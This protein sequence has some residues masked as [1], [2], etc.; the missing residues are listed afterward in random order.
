MNRLLLHRL[1]WL[2]V[3]AFLFSSMLT[4]RGQSPSTDDELTLHSAGLSADGAALLAF[5]HARA[6]TDIDRDHLLLLLRQFASG[7]K[8]ERDSATVELLGLGPLALPILRQA[9]ND[10][11]HPEVAKRAARCLPWLEGASSHKL[12]AA[13]AHLLAQRKPDGAAAALL[14]YLPFADN[15][16]VIQAVNTA[17]AAV[18]VQDGKPDPALLR[19]LTDPLAVRRAAAGIALCRATPPDRVPAVRKLLQDPAPG[20]RLHAAMALAEANDAGAIPVLIDL[21]ADLTP[22]Q[23]QPVEELLTQLAGEWAPAMQFSSED[24]ISR[25]IRRDAWASWWRHTDGPALLAAVGKHTLTPEA[26]A[27]V[28]GYIA[29]LGSEQFTSRENATRDL[30]A[31]G[32]ITLPQ[33]REAS[34]NKDPEVARRAKLLIERIEREPAHHLPVAAI[35]LLA[36]R[37]PAGVVEALLAYVPHAEDEARIEE[38]RKSLTVL[39]LRDG[40]LDPLLVRALSDT[41]PLVRV[42]AVQALAKGGGVEGR[43]AV[44]QL[45]KDDAPVVRLRVALA[46]ALAKEKDS[47]PVLIDLL[48]MLPVEH[49]GE[50]ESVLYQLAGDSAPKT[51]AGTEPA[52]K[53]KCRDAWAAWWKSNAKSVDLGRLQERPWYGYTLICDTARNR[54]YE[55]DR[56]GKERWAIDNVMQPF[57]AVVLPGNRVLIAEFNA[58]RITERDL[59]GKTLWTKQLPGNPSNVQRL[60][61][62]N[63]LVA[64]NG[65]AILEVDR[66]GKEVYRINNVPGNVLA[67]YR[68][69]QGVIVC[70]T[71]NG[72]CLLLDTTGKQLKS[73]ATHH[74]ANS[75]GGI[76]LLANGRILVTRQAQGK[77]AEYDRDGKLVLE[78][79]APGARTASGLPNGHILVAGQGT[80]RTYEMDRTGKIVWEHKDRSQPFRVRRR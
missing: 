26:R 10:L 51:V 35:R 23:R 16:D 55:I 78:L 47:I 21:L 12:L 28:A 58:N 8:E 75:M 73:F 72:Q 17:L 66:E 34:Q 68:T 79:N 45:L 2:F 43:A 39:V 50:I 46:L 59:K 29:K 60:A 27:K 64:M 54:V 57:D 13:A 36:V 76:D 7:P 33:L 48:T 37:K 67:A 42:M 71:F 19:G 56:H 44:R 52:E 4:A 1:G 74:D 22:E 11:D 20:V 15:P 24:D 62:G 3:P 65:G 6:R 49:I 61:N 5:F 70:M 63:T 53:K 77:V 32:R 14:T 31:L 80:Q 30:F 25:R 40:K 41:R 69:R 38:V 18:A 9:V